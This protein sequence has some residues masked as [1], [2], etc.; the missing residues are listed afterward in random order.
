MLKSNHAQL[1]TGI[2][3]SRN[4]EL[5]AAQAPEFLACIFAKSYIAQVDL[6]WLLWVA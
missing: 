2:A 4:G 3:E 1:D 5:P 6:L